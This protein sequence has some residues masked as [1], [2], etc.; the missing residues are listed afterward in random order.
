MNMKKSLS[1]FCLL[2]LLHMSVTQVLAQAKKEPFIKKGEIQIGAG[3]TTPLS[4]SG[5]HAGSTMPVG[6][7]SR[8]LKNNLVLGVRGGFSSFNVSQIQNGSL[9][10]HRG[11]N[12][13][14][15]V[16]LRQYMPL[17]K[18]IA[19]FAEGSL[20]YNAARSP[21]IWDDLSN[22]TRLSDF[23]HRSISVGG[24]L[25][26]TW[27]I[28]KR[29]QLDLAFNSLIAA[30]F[31]RSTQL[32]TSLISGASMLEKDNRFRMSHPGMMSINLTLRI[33]LGK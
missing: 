24:S 13:T 14:S 21:L 1:S 17:S 9:V 23:R 27:A 16:F 15:S 20:D 33:R 12:F 26:A 28:N 18:K 10:R 6:E 8:A 7:V 5:F 30:G 32:N 31:Q 19:L 25:G 3:I 29:M 22:Q 4:L 2:I 11:S